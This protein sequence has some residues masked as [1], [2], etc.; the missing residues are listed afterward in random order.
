MPAPDTDTAAID[1]FINRWVKSGGHERGS[2]QQF[3]IE[4]CDLL[5]LDRPNP[6][7][8]DN[9]LNAYTFERRVD[10]KKPDGSTVANWIDLYR[11]GCFV[12]ETKQ[13]VN[14]LRDKTDPDQPLL[15]ALDAATTK[16]VGHG[17]RGT[18]AWD[19]ALDRAR[20]QAERYIHLLPVEEGRPPFLIVCDVGHCLDV[21]AEFSCTGGQYEAF[22]DPVSCRIRLDDLHRTE[23][24]ERLSRIWTDPQSL[25]PSKHAAAVTREVA[26]AL[27]EL[28]KSLEKDGHDPQITAGFLQ[29]CLFTMIAEDIGLLPG[30]AFLELLEVTRDSPGGLPVMLQALWKDMATGSVFSPAIR[31]AIPHFNGGLF[32]DT[33]ALPLRPDQ[34]AYL[35]HAAKSDWSAVEPAIFQHTTRART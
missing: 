4:L 24:R 22:P 35:I 1:E 13:G 12:L 10:R 25:D 7:V 27:A 6:P 11:A 23:I 19:K 17:T 18:A 2:G 14:P 34:I 20:S 15:P 5:G 26:K 30:N 8:A 33:S 16:S 32:E 9:A 31:A 29:R 3:F 21:Y 28:A